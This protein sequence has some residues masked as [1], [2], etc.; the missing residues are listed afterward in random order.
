MDPYGLDSYGSYGPAPL[1]PVARTSIGH[2]GLDNY[3]NLC[4]GPLWILMVWIHVHPYVPGLYSYGPDPYR[5]PWLGL[6][7]TPMVWTAV[8]PHWL[9]SLWAP[10]ASTLVDSYCLRAYGS[11]RLGPVWILWLGLRLIPMAWI[12]MDHYGLD[13]YDFQWVGPYGLLPH[14]DPY[15]LG[16]R[17]SL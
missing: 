8:D 10:M 17:G 14:T 5:P 16:P 6:L 9:R 2:Y 11:P 7:W 1:D 4:L 13:S 15:G 12:P 3:R